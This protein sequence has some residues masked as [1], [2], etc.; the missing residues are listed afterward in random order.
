[1]ETLY[2]WVDQLIH[3][4]VCHSLLLFA[5]IYWFFVWLTDWCPSL[6]IISRKQWKFGEV[7]PPS[8]DTKKNSICF[9]NNF[10]FC[11]SCP[12]TSSQF[13]QDSAR[14][15]AAAYNDGALP[16][17]CD[18]S[19]STGTTCDPIGGQCP[20]RHHVIG[21]QCTKCA[22]GYYGFP[23]CRREWM[24]PSMCVPV[25]QVKSQTHQ[26]KW[27]PLYVPSAA[28]ECGR[29][30]C[31]EVT[32]KCICPPQTVRPTCDVCQSQTFSYHPLLGCEGCECSPSGIKD[33]TRLDCDRITGQCR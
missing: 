32:G 31:D 15:L 10:F 9:K 8:G 1:M 30:L 29:R 16:C 4:F 12:R 6:I 27:N 33:D 7:V 5:V 25:S 26:S 19:G 13:C 3:G 20:C 2:I 14:S 17:N 24:V 28:C 23:Y 18:K 11:T 21:R 22:T